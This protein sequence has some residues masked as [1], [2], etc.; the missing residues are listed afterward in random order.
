MDPSQID[1]C[2]ACKV[3][4]CAAQIEQLKKLSEANNELA[5]R[6]RELESSYQNHHVSWP[7]LGFP[8][9]EFDF[10][11]DDGNIDLMKWMACEEEYDEEI[12][13]LFSSTSHLS[14][15]EPVVS[16]RSKKRSKKRKLTKE[17]YIELNPRNLN[18]SF[19]KE[20]VQNLPTV[21]KQD[22]VEFVAN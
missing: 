22:G 9:H 3:H 16:K 21:E 15:D 17:G 13:F 11:D 8:M 1:K 12:E 18:F 10:F 14:G 7:N 20:T 19:K 6:L 4:E 5:L 2:K